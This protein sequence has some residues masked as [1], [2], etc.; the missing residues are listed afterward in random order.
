MPFLG[1]RRR[2]TQPGPTIIR[3]LTGF[4]SDCSFIHCLNAATREHELKDNYISNMKG[5]IGTEILIALLSAMD[6]QKT[7]LA[8]Q[9]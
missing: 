1:F 6:F 7:K 8:N 5:Q 4:F 3:Q 9:L 2:G